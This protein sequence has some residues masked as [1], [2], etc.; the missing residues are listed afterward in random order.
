MIVLNFRTYSPGT[1]CR[2]RDETCL[3]SL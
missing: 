2:L 1:A 3:H